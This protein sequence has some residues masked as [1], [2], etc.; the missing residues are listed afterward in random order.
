MVFKLAK[1]I[2]YR[3]PNLNCEFLSRVQLKTIITLHRLKYFEDKEWFFFVARYIRNGF[4]SISHIFVR[5]EFTAP[6]QGASSQMTFKKTMS[7]ISNHRKVIKTGSEDNERRF[8]D[9][10]L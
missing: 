5:I 10:E 7:A 9:I 3:R 8:C 2:F 1:A 6:V 4:S